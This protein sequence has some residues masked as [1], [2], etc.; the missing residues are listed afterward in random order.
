M[1]PS[2]LVTTPCYSFPRRF[3]GYIGV[4]TTIIFGGRHTKRIK[5]IVYPDN[6]LYAFSIPFRYSHLSYPGG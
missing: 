4:S 6:P 2:L 3:T 1:T 5:R